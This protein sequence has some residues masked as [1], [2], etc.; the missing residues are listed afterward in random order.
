MLST[1]EWW[2]SAIYKN[3][4][5]RMLFMFLKSIPVIVKEPD[6]VTLIQSTRKQ[7]E[8]LLEV[9]KYYEVK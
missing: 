9:R 3:L 2:I 4:I 7:S 1:E 8:T 6:L 5:S